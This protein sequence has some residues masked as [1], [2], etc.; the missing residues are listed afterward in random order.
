MVK[1]SI[2]NSY[3]TYFNFKNI[4]NE[5]GLPR[6]YGDHRLNLSCGKIDKNNSI[7]IMVEFVYK[8]SSFYFDN[9]PPELNCKINEFL[10]DKIILNIT[11]VLPD[12]YPFIQPYWILSDIITPS[13]QHDLILVYYCDKIRY[14]NEKISDKWSPAFRIEKDILVFMSTVMKFTDV[15]ET[16]Y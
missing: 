12:S 13:Q 5:M 9:L 3:N 16:I 7:N 15:F 2:I 11:M 10:Y 6:A 4:Q 14:H 8:H 1:D